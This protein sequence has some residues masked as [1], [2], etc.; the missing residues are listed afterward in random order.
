MSNDEFN[1]ALPRQ[2][3]LKPVSAEEAER[4]LLERLAK[5]GSDHLDAIWDLAC[6]YSQAGQYPIAQAYM[7]RYLRTTDDPEK[8]AGAYL[9]LGQTMERMK[10]YEAAIGFYSRALSL[11]PTNTPTWYLINNNLG[12]CLNL[13]ERFEDAENYCR[14]AIGIDPERPNAYKNLGISLAGQ[15]RYAEAARDYIRATRVQAADGRALKLLEQ[16]FQDHPEIAGEIPDIQDQIEQCR[17]AVRMVA[18]LQNRLEK[19][20]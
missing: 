12:F 10:E 13:F 20:E 17:Q 6:F 15:G 18:E 16:L 7:E 4:I 3:D 14:V 9:G 1:F 2:P 19:G 11:E 5:A 8:Q